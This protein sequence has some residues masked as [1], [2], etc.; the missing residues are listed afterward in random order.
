M[1]P[2]NVKYLHL[3]INC[4]ILLKKG[5]TDKYANTNVITIEYNMACSVNDKLTSTLSINNLVDNKCIKALAT[6][7]GLGIKPSDVT[8]HSNS[9]VITCVITMITTVCLLM[10]AKG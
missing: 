7:S 8:C 10:F 3:T 5:N 9:A 1:R 4:A 2:A 6:F